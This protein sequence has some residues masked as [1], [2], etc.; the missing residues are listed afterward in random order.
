[1]VVIT[2]IGILA[3]V[4]VPR[5]QTFRAR[6][7][8][9]EAKSGLSGLYLSME[10]FQTNYQQYPT[11]AQAQNAAAPNG[12]AAAYAT[13][14]QGIGFAV[15]GNTARYSYAVAT[16]A[17]RWAGMARS[18]AVVMDGR[19]DYH[20]VNAKKWTCT[21]FDGVSNTSATN[22]DAATAASPLECPQS[23]TAAQGIAAA[24]VAVAS[25]TPADCPG[26]IATCN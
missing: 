16:Q 8:Q 22:S 19:F 14:I 25:E 5:F 3:G 9:S 17:N 4:A 10:A 7:Q 24:P 23:I 15:Q 21:P 18:Q 6:A 26:G 20:R 11:A 1:M 12:I 2:I 13:T